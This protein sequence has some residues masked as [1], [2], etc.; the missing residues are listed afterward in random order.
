MAQTNV[1][2]PLAGSAEEHFGGRG[3]GV[4]LEE[5]MFDLPRTVVAEFVG[6]LDLG[7]R[8]LQQ[9][10]LRVLLPWSWQLVF[11]EDAEFHGSCSLLLFVLEP[12]VDGFGR[13][14]RT[15]S[16]ASFAGGVRLPSRSAW[17][18]RFLQR[19]MIRTSYTTVSPSR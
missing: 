7:E 11:V 3:M 12:N 9:L 8:V 18:D 2:R 5:V 14:Q 15:A 4:L 10:V 17:L 19:V 13:T 6:Q 1:R 16:S